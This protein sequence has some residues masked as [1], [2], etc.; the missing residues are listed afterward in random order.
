MSSLYNHSTG[1]IYRTYKKKEE[2]CVVT[3]E[4]PAV[5][6][7]YVFEDLVI[8]DFIISKLNPDE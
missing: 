6:L 4:N 8:N 5:N 2:K 1:Q 3:F 7:S